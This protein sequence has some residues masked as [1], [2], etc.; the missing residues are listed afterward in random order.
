[1]ATKYVVLSPIQH[2]QE[3]YP[4]DSEIELSDKAAK[5]LLEVSAIA[6]RPAPAPKA[7]KKPAA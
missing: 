4:V 7:E 2:D 5:P 3:I 1:M 6:P